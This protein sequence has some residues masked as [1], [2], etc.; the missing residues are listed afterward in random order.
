MARHCTICVRPE[1]A[2]IDL[3]LARGETASSIAKDHNVKIDSVLRHKANH[4]SKSSEVED[5]SSMLR[6]VISELDEAALIALSKGDHRSC[7]DARKR[8]TDAIQALIEQQIEQRK[9]SHGASDNG[10]KQIHYSV[11]DEIVNRVMKNYSQCPLCGGFTVPKA[12][13]KPTG[14]ALN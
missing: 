6:Q 1:R 8:K 11:L 10:L 7:V 9:K 2:S 3:R 13:G 14:K 5:L 4:L 12:T